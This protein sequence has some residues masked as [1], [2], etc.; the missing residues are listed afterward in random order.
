MSHAKARLI[1]GM[2]VAAVTAALTVSAL[3]LASAA[4]AVTFY[5]ADGQ[6]SR[7]VGCSS[8]GALPAT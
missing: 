8:P 1:A 2:G 5:F 6:W 7:A 4:T 3:P